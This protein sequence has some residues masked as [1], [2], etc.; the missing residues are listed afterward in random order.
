MKD[1]KEVDS[2][3][4]KTSLKNIKERYK[5]S[6]YKYEEAVP[7]DLLNIKCFLWFNLINGVKL[8][9]ANVYIFSQKINRL[10]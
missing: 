3:N 1:V 6:S 2:G 9:I 4:H 5:Y 10:M 7:V 8:S